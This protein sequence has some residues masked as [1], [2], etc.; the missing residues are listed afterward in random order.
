MRHAP[1]G[2]TM[3][4]ERRSRPILGALAPLAPL[5][6]GA[7]F[8]LAGNALLATSAAVGMDDAGYGPVVT[9]VVVTGYF[10]GFGVGSL[11][12]ERV[13][14]RVGHVRAFAGFAAV[15]AAAALGHAIVA[16]AA[17]AWFLLRLL[18]GFSIAG[19]YLVTESWMDRAGEGTDRGRLLSVYMVTTH[20]AIVAGQLLF[21]APGAEE[22][23]FR[24]YAVAALFVCV[25]VVPVAL[26]TVH[27]PPDEEHATLSLAAL[28]RVA[29]LGLFAA[30]GAGA[31]GGALYGMGPVYAKGMLGP[32]GGVSAFMTATVLGGLLAQVPVGRFSDRVDRR[33]VLAGSAAGASLAALLFVPAR[34]ALGVPAATLG[35]A[36]LVGALAL[37]LYPLALAHVFDR[38]DRKD[39]LAAV[40]SMLAAYG[41]GS[42]AG[43][44][45]VSTS[46]HALGPDGFPLFLA[47]VG[48]AVAG[49]A[50]Y[51]IG[52]VEGVPVEDQEPFVPLSRTSSALAEIDPRSAT[53][54]DDGIR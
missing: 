23:P 26:Y 12:A 30:L 39:A 27:A 48:V 2:S 3:C 17:L 10:I 38:V 50:A 40:G 21:A 44:L 20:L 31:I 8:L 25:G 53:E 4:S 43:P 37:T 51:R 49:Y 45:L 13:V 6:L 46:M 28:G 1:P 14:A 22:A 11:R 15:L 35:I 9:G 5:L 52:H 18:A 54:E 32:A 36:A 16:P 34:L 33:R 29:P 47:T 41:F 7:V 19:L 24:R 42:A